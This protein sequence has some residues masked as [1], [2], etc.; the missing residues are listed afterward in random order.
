MS[1]EILK[2]NVI[3]MKDVYDERIA[4][5]PMDAAWI[6]DRKCQAF[7]AAPSKRLLLILSVDKGGP[8]FE[9][10]DEAVEAMKWMV[11]ELDDLLGDELDNPISQLDEN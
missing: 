6:A 5:S 3:E 8:T 4:I 2:G 11:N 9:W 1:E 10:T 7:L